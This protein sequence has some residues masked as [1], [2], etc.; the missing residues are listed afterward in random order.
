MFGQGAQDVPI[1]KAF[2]KGSEAVAH[3]PGTPGS[4]LH[5]FTNALVPS[6]LT[7]RSE[8]P[9]CL[10]DGSQVLAPSEDVTDRAGPWAG[11]TPGG[12]RTHDLL[13][14]RQTLYPAELRARADREGAGV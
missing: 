1:A 12:I 6:G 3:G 9:F 14:R 7:R 2:K 10:F 4:W 5:R 8:A 13:L 11:G